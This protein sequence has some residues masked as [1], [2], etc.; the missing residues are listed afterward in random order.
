MKKVHGFL[1]E[2]SRRRIGAAALRPVPNTFHEMY[3]LW[4]EVCP[5]VIMTDPY[6]LAIVRNKRRGTAIA[7][8]HS[9]NDQALNHAG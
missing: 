7:K 9:L 8:Q 1:F 6:S 3:V 5:A 4:I 2:K